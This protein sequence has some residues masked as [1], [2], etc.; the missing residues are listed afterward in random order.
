MLDTLVNN[1]RIKLIGYALGV[2]ISYTFYGWFQEKL[3]FVN[4]ERQ[5]GNET[6]TEHFEFPIA[7][8]GIQCVAYVIVAKS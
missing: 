8:T 5:I 3:F 4:Y 2:F 7:F 6:V 1:H